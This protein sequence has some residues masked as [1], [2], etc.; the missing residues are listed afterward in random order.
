MHPP[1]D[2]MR[3]E[4]SYS[5]K[6]EAIFRAQIMSDARQ[7]AAQGAPLSSAWYSL[8][9]LQEH[10]SAVAAA[11]GSG[12]AVPPLPRGPNKKQ[13]KGHMEVDCVLEERKTM[14]KAGGWFL[15]RWAGYHPSWE[16]YRIHGNVGSQLETWEPLK[17]VRHCTELAIFRA[18]IK[19]AKAIPPSS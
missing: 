1:K 2:E 3:R 13:K 10:A 7:L 11:E 6:E 9:G 5:I 8:I 18:A 19:A 12:S 14:G 15:V 4:I 16:K 17:N